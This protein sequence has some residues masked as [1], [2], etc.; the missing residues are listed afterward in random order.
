MGAEHGQPVAP[1]PMS[2]RWPT[3]TPA[4]RCTTRT[5]TSSASSRASASRGWGT[6]G[7]TSASAPIDR[8]GGC[9]LAGNGAPTKY[10]PYPYAH[11]VG[12]NDVTSGSNGSCGGIATLLGNR[13]AHCIHRGSGTP[14]GTNGLVGDVKR[15][16]TEDG[17]RAD[18]LPCNRRSTPP[19]P[20]DFGLRRICKIIRAVARNDVV[21]SVAAGSP[22]RVRVTLVDHHRDRR[23]PAARVT[24]IESR[25]QSERRKRGDGRVVAHAAEPDGG[26]DVLFVRPAVEHQER[27]RLARRRNSRLQLGCA[28]GP[29]ST[30]LVDSSSGPSDE[31]G[32]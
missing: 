25:P 6:V 1:S 4:S 23:C 2:R 18:W 5:A 8:G 9:A 17:D 15:R 29:F 30:D 19:P 24:R 22:C 20:A 14:N 26:A 31:L 7:G 16:R 12:L 27:E 28:R 10:A 13:R 11:T 3:R 32:R 21:S